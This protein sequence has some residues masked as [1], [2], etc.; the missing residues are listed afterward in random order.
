MHAPR[1]YRTTGDLPAVIPVFPLTGAL[2]L[3]RTRLPLNIFEP[4]Y[5]AMIDSALGSYR[6]IGMIQP[7]VAGEE[8][9]SAK[10]PPLTSVGCAGRIV[11][12][13]ASLIMCERRTT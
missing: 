7:K 11:E 13:V 3:P 6:I 8:E 4:R 1:R 2:L 9:D 5:L 10:R 12:Y